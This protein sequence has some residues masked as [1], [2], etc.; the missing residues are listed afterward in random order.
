MQEVSLNN[1]ILAIIVLKEEKYKVGSGGVPIF[2]VK[3]KEE[4]EK[5]SM[6]LARIT[7]GMVHD[8]GNGVKLIIKH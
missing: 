2:Y 1:I 8:L 7:L 3:N 5:I 4:Q 6:L